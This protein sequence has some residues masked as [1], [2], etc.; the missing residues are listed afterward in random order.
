MAAQLGAAEIEQTLDRFV[1]ADQQVY[2]RTLA[3]YG[4]RVAFLSGSLANTEAH[5]EADTEADT[6]MDNGVALP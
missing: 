6:E 1:A 4:D 3:E 2:A 5:T